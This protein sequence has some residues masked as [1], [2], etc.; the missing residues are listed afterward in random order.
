ML[1]SQDP[2]RHEASYESVPMSVILHEDS[3]APP[4]EPLPTYHQALLDKAK[5]NA[6]RT[7]TA[8]IRNSSPINLI[9]S[10]EVRLTVRGTGT[11]RKPPTVAVLVFFTI[12]GFAIATGG[13]S[14]YRLFSSISLMIVDIV[15]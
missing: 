3:L 10:D 8:P 2:G 15:T 5:S 7:N 12:L 6:R 1:S 11:S 14:R 4:D 9:P 13:I